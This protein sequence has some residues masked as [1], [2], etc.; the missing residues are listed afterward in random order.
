M[1]HKRETWPDMA[2][3]IGIIL[4]VIGHVWRGLAEAGIPMNEAVFQA[5][6]RGIYLFHMPLFFFISGWFFPNVLRH[7]TAGEQL[8][9]PVSRLLYPM[10]IWTYLFALVK[11][12]AGEAANDPVSAMDLLR[13]PLPPY[14]HLWFLWALF[15]LQVGVFALCRLPERWAKAGTGLLFVA[16]VVMFLCVARAENVLWRGTLFGAPFFL[17]GML[18][19]RFGGW[20]QGRLATG[21]ALFGFVAA[22]VWIG[23]LPDLPPVTYLCGAMACIIAVLTLARASFLSARR[24]HSQNWLTVLGRASMTIFLTHTIFAAS[25]RI[26]LMKAGVTDIGVHLVMGAVLGLM[27]PLGFESRRVPT[28]LRRFLGFEPWSTRRNA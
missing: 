15:V 5:V 14:L 22:Q 2:K 27:L 12:A 23:T 18:W 10:V 3:G 7:G 21:F 20:P 16:S 25:V 26:G 13:W 9:R 28:V 1:T 24:R 6:D 8:W 17:L 4:V 19:G 11:L